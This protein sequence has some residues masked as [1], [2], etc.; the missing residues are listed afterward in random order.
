MSDKTNEL[1]ELLAEHCHGIPQCGRAVRVQVRR[2]A[3]SRRNADHPQNSPQR[4]FP[5]CLQ[6]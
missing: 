4:Q 2:S 3:D 6:E 1:D 5:D